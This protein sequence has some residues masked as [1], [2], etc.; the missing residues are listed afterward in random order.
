MPLEALRIMPAV[1]EGLRK[2]GFRTIGDL[3]DQPR[4]PLTLRFGHDLARRIEQMQGALAEPIEPVRPDDVIE[5]R[6]AFAEPI[7]AAE[8]IARYIGKLV[9]QLCALL[10]EHGL[11]ARRLDL[12]CQ[13]V[14]SRAQAVRVGMAAPV[15]DTKRL[16]R[17]LCDKIETI[18]PGFG[19]EVMTLAATVVE[20]LEH[21]QSI[22]SL[23]EES[24]PDITSLI[25]VLMN[26]VMFISAYPQNAIASASPRDPMRSPR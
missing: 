2:L 25:D 16:T 23:I 20:P 17:L 21:K 8:T 7:G 19:I 13:R 15:R 5:V 9:I 18:S 14:D 11:G 10:E 1:A 24:A 4:A 26:R 3:L 22:S 6:R 12:I